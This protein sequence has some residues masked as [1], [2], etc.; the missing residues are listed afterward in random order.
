M[1]MIYIV[2]SIFCLRNLCTM[3]NFFLFF[4]DVQMSNQ[5]QVIS[6]DR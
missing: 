6:K 4:I 5:L 3:I 1:K 2:G